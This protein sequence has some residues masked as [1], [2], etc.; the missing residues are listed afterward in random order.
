MAKDKALVLANQDID[1]Q[2]ASDIVY[3]IAS[4][5]GDGEATV[6]WIA[7]NY[8]MTKREALALISHP[9]FALLLH[10]MQKAVARVQFDRKAYKTLD[11]IIDSGQNKDKIA[12]IKLCAE[13]LDYKK[14]GGPQV[15]VNIKFDR[16]VRQLEGV[17]E[18]AEEEVIDADCEDV[19]DDYPG[20]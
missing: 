11:N 18:A 16:L 5:E 4:G 2:L 7:E 12:A 14:D 3:E 19:S 9:Q 15:Q 20:L 6:E 13:L 17:P 1:V 8:G 10:N